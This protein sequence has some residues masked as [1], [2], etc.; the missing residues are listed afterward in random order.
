[1]KLKISGVSS[2]Q[3]QDFLRNAQRLI[4][5]A[6]APLRLSEV[7]SRKNEEV[8]Y[9]RERTWGEF[10]LEKLILTPQEIENIQNKALAAIELA[11]FPLAENPQG[12][13]GKVSSGGLKYEVQHHFL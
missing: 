11:F 9:L 13:A 3:C 6:K 10:F 1:M 5:K 8:L 4:N 2:S 7:R 12:Q